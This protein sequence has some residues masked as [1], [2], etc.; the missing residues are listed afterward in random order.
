MADKETYV[1]Q[2]RDSWQE[3]SGREYIFIS[4][5]SQDWERVYPCVLALR[6][7]GV[8]AFIDT[9]FQ[10]DKGWLKNIEDRLFNDS[11]C[12]GM[13]AFVSTGYLGSYAC[14]AELLANRTE[15]QRM[16]RG[17]PLPVLYLALEEQ[18]RTV[19]GI[20][21]HIQCREVHDTLAKIPVACT[22]AELSRVENYLLSLYEER[23][24][25][26]ELRKRKLLNDLKEISNR[27][28]VAYFMNSLIFSTSSTEDMPSF[29]DRK[30]VV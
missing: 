1:R 24:E 13:V 25:W 16:K 3:D 19:Q 27:F 9:N 15:T 26:Q 10:R 14:L 22:P 30:S 12:R 28:N 23:G 6:E 29:Q 4:Y 8:R 17:K 11:R 18:L 20:G 21:Q 5:A 2:L 7:L